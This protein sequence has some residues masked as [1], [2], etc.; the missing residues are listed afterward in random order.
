MS[1]RGLLLGLFLVRDVSAWGDAGH[2]IICEI[3]FQELNPQ[4]RA[5]VQRLL[6]HDADFSTFSKACTWPDRPRKRA[7]EHFVN[8][9]RAATQ[10]GDEPCPLDAPCVVTAIDADFAALSRAGATD[11]AKL[12]ALK[13]LGHWVGDVHQPLHVSFKDDKGG[14]EIDEEGPCTQNLH[15]VWDTC[16][17]KRKLGTNLQR[18]AADLRRPVTEAERTQWTSTSAKEWANESF[19]ITTSE[20]AEYCVRTETGCRYEEDNETLDPDEDH[21]V[22]TVDEAYLTK[23]LPTVRQRLTQAGVRLGTLLNRALDGE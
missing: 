19:A 5:T 8:L 22:V 3:A 23:H 18:I 20:E 6:Q 2:Q 13:F 4:A 7:S 11:A 1:W 9:P 14:N 17:I 15:A 21:K 16:I 10:I 12:T